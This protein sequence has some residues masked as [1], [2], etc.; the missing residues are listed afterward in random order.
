MK[1]VDVMFLQLVKPMIPK[2]KPHTVLLNSIFRNVCILQN[3]ILPGMIVMFRRR[4]V[5]GLIT[6]ACL[7]ESNPASFFPL[8][9]AASACME[10]L[11]ISNHIV[12]L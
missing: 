7:R 6:L 4:L 9:P 5:L 11:I 10:S 2:T 3:S 8:K 1:L 12:Y